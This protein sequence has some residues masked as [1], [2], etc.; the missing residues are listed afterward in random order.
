M[1]IGGLFV[2]AAEEL[3]QIAERRGVAAAARIA[4]R[5]GRRWRAAVREHGWDGD[6]FRRAYDYFGAPVGSAANDEGQIFIE[7]QGICVDGRH[8]ARRRPRPRRRSRRCAEQLAT[9]HG[10]VLQQPAYSGYHLELGEIS[11]YPPGLQGERRHLLPHEP[12][13]R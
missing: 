12:V 6:W 11:S 3:A 7:P 9:P 1:F 8:R 10:I 5:R 2:L 4:R 13:D